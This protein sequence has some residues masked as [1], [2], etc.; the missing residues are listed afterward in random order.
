VTAQPASLLRW[1]MKP[2]RERA[3]LSAQRIR[4]S[5]HRVIVSAAATSG[6]PQAFTI[7]GKDG[8]ETPARTI[9]GYEAH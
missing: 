4:S 1:R 8:Q 3:V 2:V 5:A 7:S 9:G 6:F